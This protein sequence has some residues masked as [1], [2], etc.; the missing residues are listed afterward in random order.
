[1]K[2]FEVLQK[3]KK[4][5]ALVRSILESKLSSIPG[6]QGKEELVKRALRGEVVGIRLLNSLAVDA[7]T[8]EEKFFLAFTLSELARKGL[9]ETLEGLSLLSVSSSNYY[10]RQ[11]A[12]YGLVKLAKKGDVRTLPAL[13]TI[14][15][16]MGLEKS[17]VNI[18]I[19]AVEGL[20]YLARQ[21]D[22]QAQEVL[23]KHYLK[24]D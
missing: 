16:G 12:V 19:L 10:V 22:I 17:E 15:E 11:R 4:N 24:W 13:K 7:E 21:K 18:K 5:A 23:K 1:M 3:Q 8:T 9:S 20:K 6:A 2:S 14:F